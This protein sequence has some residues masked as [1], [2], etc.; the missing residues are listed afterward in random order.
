MPALK[1]LIDAGSH[2]LIGWE[3]DLSSQ[4]GACQAGILHGCNRDMPAFRWLEKE[5][6]NKLISS[7]GPLDA[8]LIE[9]RISNK[10][11]L[12]ASNGASRSNLFSGDAPSVMFTYSQITNMSRFY[13]DAWYFFYS[14]PY[15]FPHTIAL[16]L[17]DVLR[18]LRSRY[19]QW[20]LD[21]RPRLTHIGTY[22][23]L[24]AFANV[25]LREMTTFTLI[26]DIARGKHDAIYSTYVAYDEIAHHS[27]VLDRESIYSLRKLDRH[28][29]WLMTA[30]IYS[31]R[32][33]SFVFLSDHGQSNGSTFLQ[34]Y[35]LSLEDLVRSL[36][37]GGTTIY[38]K[39][40]TNQDHFGQ[41]LEHPV[42]KGSE[43][44]RDRLHVTLKTKIDDEA[45]S[46][47]DAS[48]VV[49]A[50]GNLGLIYFTKWK[51]HLSLERLEAS[52]PGLIRG[53]VSHEG[54][55]FIMVR[56]DEL[57]YVVIGRSG[58]HQL[59]TGIVHGEDPL[60]SFGEN[61]AAH[62]RR[63]SGFRYLPDILVNGSY[64]RETDEVAAFEELGGE[65]SRPFLMY[66]VEC[67]VDERPIVGAEQ[68]HQILKGLVKG[69]Q[70]PQREDR[71]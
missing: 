60:S 58:T 42:E 55:G 5:N 62:L 31:P 2:R 28:F 67:K 17:W 53:L 14:G 35:G 52:F 70:T 1:G 24:R 40:D 21:V 45:I 26:G 6:G 37:P 19:I 20:R 69:S 22:P 15:N 32:K 63:T 10:Q 48:V 51:D 16:F 23:I 38:S 27:G 66:P 8:P 44:L 25:F 71:T 50:S 68:V 49:L 9:R 47:R 64:Y 56:S 33:Y 54:I 39:L 18:E 61:A 41:A 43:I 4:T 36:L 30:A 57:G 3:T 34:R 65:Q 12:L 13:N 29:K 46:L 11:G 7:T 59:E